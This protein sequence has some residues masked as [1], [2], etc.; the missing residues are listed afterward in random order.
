MMKMSKKKK[1]GPVDKTKWYRCLCILED[2]K[3]VE[4][5]VFISDSMEHARE[6]ALGKVSHPTNI[7][8]LSE[9]EDWA[10]AATIEKP[11]KK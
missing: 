1:K 5:M 4:P 7:I 11:P 8:E 2:G 10:A 3:A 6:Y 9:H